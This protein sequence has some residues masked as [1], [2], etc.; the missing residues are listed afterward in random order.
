MPLV[1]G[2]IGKALSNLVEHVILDMRYH[3]KSQEMTATLSRWL[4]QS[5]FWLL[6]AKIL[7]DKNVPTFRALDLIDI[8]EV[9]S[10]VLCIAERR[11]PL[12]L[13]TENRSIMLANGVSHQRRRPQG[14]LNP[15]CRRERPVS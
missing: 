15:C 4:F 5:A 1:E 14:D 8:D 3:L 9:F 7:R 11:K 2:E 12:S 10:H 13:P 6:A